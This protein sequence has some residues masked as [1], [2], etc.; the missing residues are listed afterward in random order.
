MI[1]AVL[2]VGGDGGG[3]GCGV[4][5]AAV[6]YVADTVVVA[7]TIADSN[8]AELST[9]GNPCHFYKGAGHLELFQRPI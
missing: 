3:G 8:A 2:V 1:V 6:V 9:Y 7:V 5:A 4:A